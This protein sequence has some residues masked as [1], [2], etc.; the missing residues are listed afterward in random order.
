MSTVSASSTIG[1]VL[2]PPQ[3]EDWLTAIPA[4][5]ALLNIDPRI[6][7]PFLLAIGSVAK[8]ISGVTAWPS[9]RT[10][11]DWA[12]LASGVLAAFVSLAGSE[13]AIYVLVAG[14]LAKGLADVV[15]KQFEDLFLVVMA[16]A[17]GI[18]SFAGFPAYANYALEAAALGKAL[19]GIFG[20]AYSATVAAA[21][22]A[23]A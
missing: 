12:L 14:Y 22:P 23:T 2:T 21:K 20:S 8:G 9:A 15:N 5:I 19:P 6:S 13:Y 7:V 10:W 4:F 11:Q 3:L 1:K 18:L 16:L 17:G